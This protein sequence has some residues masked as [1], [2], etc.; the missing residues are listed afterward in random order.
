M[1][2]DLVTVLAILDGQFKLAHQKEDYDAMALIVS[3]KQEILA[4]Y[5]K[6]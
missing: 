5:E 6:Q 3:I 2:I 4:S 1:K